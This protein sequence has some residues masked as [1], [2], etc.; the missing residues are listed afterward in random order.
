MTKLNLGCADDFKSGYINV[1]IFDP[2]KAKEGFDYVQ[3]DLS[4]DLYGHWP[5]S[6]STIDFIAASDII[7][8]LPD[9]IYTMN[10][11]WRV[12]KPGGRVRIEVP[13]TDGTGAFQ[14]PTHVS[15]WN[16]RSFLYYEDGNPYRE[17]FADSYGISAR[18]RVVGETHVLTGDGPKLIIVMEAVK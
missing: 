18:F 2:V 15:F 14:D 12:L 6:D 10:E 8:H 13:T 1:D 5:W 17:R 16:R 4:N 7:E 9:K 3:F 11:I